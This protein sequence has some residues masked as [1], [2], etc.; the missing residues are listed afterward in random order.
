M[1]RMTALS[2]AGVLALSA[3]PDALAWGAYHGG[4]GGAR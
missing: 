2:I 4:Y 1:K 3:A